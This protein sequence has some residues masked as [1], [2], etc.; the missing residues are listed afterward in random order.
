MGV[1]TE[2]RRAGLDQTV[3][4]LVMMY[5]ILTIPS[6]PMSFGMTRFVVDELVDFATAVARLLSSGS[7]QG[8]KSSRF[9]I[10]CRGL[11]C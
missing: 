11:K 5:V 4:S 8:V 3:L 10:V 6:S 7:G 1:I 2:I 9:F